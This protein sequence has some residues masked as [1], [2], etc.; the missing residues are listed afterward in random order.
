MRSPCFTVYTAIVEN[1][2]GGAMKRRS[3]YT[4]G[5]PDGVV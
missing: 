5:F 1:D 2:E 4:I 3:K